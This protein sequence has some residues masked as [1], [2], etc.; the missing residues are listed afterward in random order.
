M[1]QLGSPPVAKVPKLSSKE[2]DAARVSAGHVVEIH[3]RLV[4]FIREGHTLAQIDAQCAKALKDLG[5][6]SCFRHYRPGRMPPFPSYA[7][8]SLN[9]CVVHGTATYETRPIQSGDLLS[10]DIGVMHKGWI[11]DAA[12]TYAI[13]QQSDTAKALMDCGKESLLIGIKAM[14]PGAPFI[15]WARAVQGY[16]EGEC[17][18]HCSRGLGGHGIGRKLHA[19]PFIANVDPSTDPTLYWQEALQAWAPGNLVAV[20]PMIN[21]GT[22]HT[23]QSPNQW[24][25]Y[26]ADGSLSVHY[27]ADV[28]ITVDGPENLTLGL[29]DMPDVI[30]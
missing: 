20:E 6:K 24:P 16:V 1:V 21:V 30:G 5:C 12:W 10:I 14:Q 23:S 18:F 15:D 13:K 26:T 4:D 27:E 17:G 8:L 29:Y 22:P 11:G 9:E 28:L 7:C 2:A 25:V 19:P 3:H